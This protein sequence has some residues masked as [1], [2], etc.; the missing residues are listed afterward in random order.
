MEERGWRCRRSGG[1]IGLESENFTGSEAETGE[2]RSELESERQKDWRGKDAA[3]R[4]EVG[5]KLLLL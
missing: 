4:T 3:T 2:R 1:G 5:E